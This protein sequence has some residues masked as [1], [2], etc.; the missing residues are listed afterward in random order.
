MALAVRLGRRRSTDSGVE[1]NYRRLPLIRV[2]DIV[3]AEEGHYHAG[4][5]R[6]LLE[7]LEVGLRERHTDGVW[8]HLRGVELRRSDRARLCQRRALVRLDTIRILTTARCRGAGDGGGGLVA[9]RPARPGWDCADCGEEW[10]CPTCRARLLQRYRDNRLALFRYLG[11]I[12]DEAAGDL[13]SLPPRRR[14]AR[15]VGWA[16]RRFHDR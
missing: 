12:L 7:V 6:L 15:F 2:G 9:H 3:T 4:L 1:M 16:R 10:P 14:Y 11:R 8:Q 13:P 5:G